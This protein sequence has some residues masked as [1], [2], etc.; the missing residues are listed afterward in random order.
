MSCSISEFII[1]TITR[2]FKNPQNSVQSVLT[3]CLENYYSVSKY[4]RCAKKKTPEF[5]SRKRRSCF[6]S[7]MQMFLKETTWNAIKTFLNKILQIIW[8][9]WQLELWTFLPASKTVYDF[10]LL[11]FFLLVVLSGY[12]PTPALPSHNCCNFLLFVF[13]S[14]V[15]TKRF[16]VHTPNWRITL[17]YIYMYFEGFFARRRQNT[18]ASLAG[19]GRCVNAN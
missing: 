5:S 7:V 4:A 9:V 12:I 18:G 14:N 19:E 13:V 10:S 1:Y 3:S 11:N 15:R 16:R 8:Q 6:A 17:V 2:G